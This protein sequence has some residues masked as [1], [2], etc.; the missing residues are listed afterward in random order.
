MFSDTAEVWLRL[1]KP[2]AV[3]REY[4][5]IEW[6]FTMFTRTSAI[7]DRIKAEI[8]AEVKWRYKEICKF[9]HIHK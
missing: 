7:T 9:L 1:K 4:Q 2:I 5:K 8:N 3:D 6:R